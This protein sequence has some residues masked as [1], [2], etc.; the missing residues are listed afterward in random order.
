M[1]NMKIENVDGK[2]IVYLYDE[3]IDIDDISNLNKKIK[4][5]FIRIMKRGNYD[6]YGYSKVSVYHND[7]YGIIL[8]VEKIY[9]SDNY[10]IIDLKIIV[11]KYV[12]MYLEF[13]DY[14]DF[15]NDKEI[16][17]NS[18]YYLKINDKLDIYKYIEY[19]RI[20]YK[21]ITK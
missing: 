16:I 20:K 8:E 3:I 9:N 17:S 12:P 18:K 14:Y 10:Q 5:V 19:G 21:K 6:F 2:T 1:I 13:D 11:Y 7:N 4:D 15:F